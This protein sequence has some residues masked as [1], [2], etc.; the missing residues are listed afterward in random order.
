MVRDRSKDIINKREAMM[1]SY[2]SQAASA[3]LA[4][5]REARLAQLREARRNRDVLHDQQQLHLKALHRRRVKKHRDMMST[6]AF[7]AGLAYL[8]E[9]R[10]NMD[11]LLKATLPTMST[12]PRPSTTPRAMNAND[13]NDDDSLPP[14][15]LFINGTFQK[16]RRSL[17][18]LDADELSD[19]DTV[20]MTKSPEL[21]RS[22]DSNK[23]LKPAATSANDELS[24]GDT[25]VVMTKSPELDRFPSQELRP[26]A[27][28]TSA[29]FLSDDDDDIK[30]TTGS[31]WTISDDDDNDDDDDEHDDNY[32]PH[33]QVKN[34]KQGLRR[35]RR[36]A[37]LSEAALEDDGNKQVAVLAPPTPLSP[38]HSVCLN[39]D[40]LEGVNK[41]RT[42][43]EAEVEVEGLA[44]SLA[45]IVGTTEDRPSNFDIETTRPNNELEAVVSTTE[46]TRLQK[47]LKAA[48]KDKAGLEVE[49]KGLEDKLEG[50]RVF[51]AA[52]F[53][54]S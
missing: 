51:N 17:S 7:S 15:L 41:G 3:G 14:R 5:L 54:S 24:D 29:I 13:N 12:L 40:E 53:L 33:H 36:L 11:E 30:S 34:V 50:W 6:P 28:A 9:A 47:E 46:I 23:D 37:D 27:T 49:V 4:Q 44:D 2:T 43:L 35:S 18:E 10:R 8:G 38:P 19:D 31:I 16:M 25:T 20:V 45:V 1:A 48:A 21:D 26:G 32:V 39:K 52:F 22:G 42:G